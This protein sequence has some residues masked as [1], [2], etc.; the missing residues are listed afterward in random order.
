MLKSASDNL[1]VET[2]QYNG[3][4]GGALVAQ[5]CDITTQTKSISLLDIKSTSC[6]SLLKFLP[7]KTPTEIDF[8]VNRT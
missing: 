2:L 8:S 7:S 6:G 3:G 4:L 5:L 1:L